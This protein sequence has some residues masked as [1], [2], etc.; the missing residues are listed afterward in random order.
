M[1]PVQLHPT[2]SPDNL[3]RFSSLVSALEDHRVHGSF[4]EDTFRVPRSSRGALMKPLPA[5]KGQRRVMFE[6]AP[7]FFGGRGVPLSHLSSGLAPG[8]VVK[9]PSE[10]IFL[11]RNVL[12]LRV[13]WPG[14]PQCEGVKQLPIPSP[15][16]RVD[17]ALAV[18]GEY[19]RLME[20]ARFEQFQAV[21]REG[22]RVGKG[23]IALENLI[24][25]S[26]SNDSDD[27]YEAEIHVVLGRNDPAN[28]LAALRRR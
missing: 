10:P 23:C 21:G 20:R 8:S 27:I 1:D 9:D 15:A 19:I 22:W 12:N 25:V 7:N 2:L 14:Y 13:S 24:L 16:T 17:V 11:G 4:I 26:I 18:V 3:S 28:M 5:W 6:A